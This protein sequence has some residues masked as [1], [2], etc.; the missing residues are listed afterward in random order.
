MTSG[1]AIAAAVTYCGRE[2]AP[3]A[4]IDERREA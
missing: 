3:I 1:I 4:N 2:F